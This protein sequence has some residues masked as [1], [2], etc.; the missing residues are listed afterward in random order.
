MIVKNKNI[1]LMIIVII[2]IFIFIGIGTFMLNRM[3]FRTVEEEEVELDEDISIPVVKGDSFLENNVTVDNNTV[4]TLFNYFREDY[5]CMYN[6]AGSINSS[7]KVRLLVAYNSI[8]DKYGEVAKCGEFNNLVINNKYFCG[9]SLNINY[10]S[11]KRGINSNEFHDYVKNS[12][13]YIVDGGL[14]DA[15]MHDIFGTG[16]SFANEDFHYANNSYIHYDNNKK[17]YIM[18]KYFNNNGLCKNYDEE[19][20]SVNSNNGVL[21]M[22][23]V[24]KDR[25]TVIR[26]IGRTFRYDDKTGKYI[27]QNRYLL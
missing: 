27:F 1:K 21:E 2:V 17:K 6:Y 7:N 23:S 4:Q 10:D 16:L 19:L 9:N 26:T 8:L 12:N 13:T 22:K 5:N 15:Q 24:L 18:Y 14:M 25:S 20:I 3:L 11:Y